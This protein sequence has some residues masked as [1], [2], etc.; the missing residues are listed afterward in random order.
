MKFKKLLAG[1][2]AGCE[3]AVHAMTQM[4]EDSHRQ[5]VI[6]VDAFH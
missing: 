5:A 2:L 1:Q 6:L 3:A 4:F